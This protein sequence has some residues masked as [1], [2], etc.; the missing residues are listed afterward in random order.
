MQG[1]LESVEDEDEID[2]LEREEKND[3]DS[4]EDV[5]EYLS[6]SDEEGQQSRK[7]LLKKR[8]RVKIGYD[9]EDNLQ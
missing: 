8:P 1:D 9:D 4:L 2:M 6:H 5:A 3:A 7:T